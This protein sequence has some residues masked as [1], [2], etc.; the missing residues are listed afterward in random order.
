MVRHR[1]PHPVFSIVAGQGKLKIR[2]LGSFQELSYRRVEKIRETD[3]LSSVMVYVKRE[4][5]IIP[6][7]SPRAVERGDGRHV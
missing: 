4:R 2:D 7:L 6:T 1:L 3:A 5:P